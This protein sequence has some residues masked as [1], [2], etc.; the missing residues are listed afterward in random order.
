M[1]GDRCANAPLPRAEVGPVQTDEA[2]GSLH[3]ALS[4]FLPPPLPP[5]PLP[6][7]DFETRSCYTGRPDLE[8]YLTQA[9]FQLKILLPRP[10]YPAKR[11]VPS[12][13]IS[14]PGSLS[15]CPRTELTY[16][17]DRGGVH[18]CRDM[19]PGSGRGCVGDLIAEKT[20]AYPK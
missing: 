15:G 9:S 17:M 18:R 11:F 8:L 6:F 5:L 3:L 10:S 20:S 13:H 2:L 16:P 12:T 14:F 19:C 4:S 1:P 7:F